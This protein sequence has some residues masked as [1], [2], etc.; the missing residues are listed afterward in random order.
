MQT[1]GSREAD[2]QTMEASDRGLLVAFLL[3]LY[4]AG[5]TL[6]LIGLAL[7]HAGETNDVAILALAG[8]GYVLAALLYAFRNRLPEWSFD[9]AA[10]SA[11]VLISASIYFTVSN[12]TGAF[13]YLWVVLAAAYFFERRRVALQVAIV[14]VG[15]AL[16]LALK[17]PEPGMVAAWIITM[18]TLTIAGALL[19]ITR[20]RVA[21]LVERLAEAADTDPLTGLLNRRGFA[22][23]LELELERAER[24]ETAMSLVAG[25]LD[26]FKQVNDR[27]GHQ[28]G[29]D[30]LAEVADV[31]RSFARRIDCVARVGGEEFALL[32][33][34]T[35]ARG[36]FIFAERLRNRVRET[37]GSRY[38]G[39]TISFGIASYPEDGDSAE[40]LERSADES[41]YAA[42]TLGRDRTVIY[43]RE[44]V[45]ALAAG[46][47]GGTAAPAGSLAT[48]LTLAEALD[49]RDHHTARHS[50]AVGRYAAA[51]ARELGLAAER[52][53]RIRVAAVLHDIG[54]IGVPDSVLLKP[55]P[56][57]DD[58][59]AEIKNHPETGARLLNTPGL[60]DL[61]A[62]ILAHHERVDGTG[63]P[64]GLRG[65]EIPLEARIIAVADAFEAML[66]DRPYRESRGPEEAIAEL[67]RCA[68][69]QFD[70]E[71]VEALVASG[72]VEAAAEPGLN[73]PR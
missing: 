17:P 8:A 70:A 72:V 24:A 38:P 22:K 61:R 1:K 43:T 13:F 35:D 68:G 32:V 14:G 51:M 34:S 49:V 29:D 10:A 69:T 50:Q 25:D 59:W 37:F 73:R 41:L 11:S 63:Y 9:L 7:P 28:V 2:S 62:W 64:L 12:S 46:P 54:K 6:G 33:P 40:R 45:G 57:T 39:L 3:G 71:V 30:V 42:K 20:E 65:E 27:Y 26:H 18:G 21:A 67:R 47:G 48:L 19:M 66:T 5:P 15:Y 36:A 56:L 52:V 53:E 23:Q 60:D 44:V 4:T 31:L 16:A 55:G 58:E